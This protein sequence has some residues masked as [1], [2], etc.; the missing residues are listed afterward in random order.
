M[1]SFTPAELLEQLKAIRGR[2]PM[3]ITRDKSLKMSAFCRVHNLKYL[4]ASAYF[5]TVAAALLAGIKAPNGVLIHFPRQSPEIKNNR[6]YMLWFGEDIS[7]I[8][9]ACAFILMTSQRS[10]LYVLRCSN[11][12]LATLKVEEE[13]YE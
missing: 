8:E 6:A 4:G 7:L 9:E 5:N 11:A 2:A 1:S 12:P 10:D 3:K 13:R